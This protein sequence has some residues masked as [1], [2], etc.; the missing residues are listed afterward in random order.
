MAFEADNKHADAF[1]AADDNCRIAGVRARS[2]RT[3]CHH[4]IGSWAGAGTAC[5]HRKPR[6]QRRSENRVELVKGP[7]ADLDLEKDAGD[8]MCQALR[9]MIGRGT[10]W[11]GS[12]A[13]LLGLHTLYAP[14]W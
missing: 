9:V 3:H 14:S 11:G 4:G 8:G 6:L 7:A 5:G 2:R 13:T 1:T 10:L 12:G